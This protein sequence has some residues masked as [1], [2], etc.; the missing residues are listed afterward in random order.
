MITASRLRSNIYRLLDEVAEN[1]RPLTVSR[2][3]TIL[4][5]CRAKSPTK[6]DR[7]VSHACIKGD[8]E[9]LVHLDWEGEWE[10]DLS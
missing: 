1:G 10:H 7:L 9:S 5:I 2:K 6:L 4:K 8:P 3:N